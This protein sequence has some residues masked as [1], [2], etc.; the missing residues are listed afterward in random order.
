[1]RSCQKVAEQLVESPNT[2]LQNGCAPYPP[3][4]PTLGHAYSAAPQPSAPPATY[5]TGTPH[6]SPNAPNAAGPPVYSFYFTGGAA[7][8]TQLPGPAYPPYSV[9]PQ[10]DVPPP[11]YDFAVH[12]GYTPDLPQASNEKISPAT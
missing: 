12:V 9:V 1:M 10:P 3:G 4:N 8:P 6:P 11:S 2:A 5:N 7:Y